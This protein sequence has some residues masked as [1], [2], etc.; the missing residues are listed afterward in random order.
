MFGCNTTNLFVKHIY[1]DGLM[2]ETL[3]SIANALEL[4]MSFFH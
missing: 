3:N 2:Q 4:F 1:M